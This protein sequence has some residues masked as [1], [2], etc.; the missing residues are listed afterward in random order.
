MDK[1]TLEVLVLVLVLALLVGISVCLYLSFSLC[2]RI[3]NCNP[4][5]FLNILINYLIFKSNQFVK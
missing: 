3:L 2:L 5:I 1:M 4:S